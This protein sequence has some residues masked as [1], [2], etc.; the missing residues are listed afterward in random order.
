M[1]QHMIGRAKMEALLVVRSSFSD[2]RTQE[3]LFGWGSF[4]HCGT[5]SIIYYDYDY[6]HD[7]PSTPGTPDLLAKPKLQHMAPVLG[8]D[9]GN[10][11]Q[12]ADLNR[13]IV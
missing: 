1:T 8:S 4:V 6:L 2:A 9:G 13:K 7:T 3:P 10:G 5:G 11:P 12:F